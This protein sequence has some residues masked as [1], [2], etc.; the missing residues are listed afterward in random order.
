MKLLHNALIHTLDP[1]IPAA[2]TIAIENGRVLA[3]GGTELLELGKTGDREDLGGR[4]VLPG[5]IDAHIHL[6]EYTLSL[7]I[8][9]CEVET[10]AEILKRVAERVDRTPAGEWV[11]GHGWNQNTWG[12]EWPKAA[13]LDEI[14]PQNPVY[15]TAKS[16][17]VSWANSLALKLAGISESTP[18]PK[19]GRIQHDSHGS[20]TGLLFEDAVKLLEKAI[21]EPDPFSLGE[22][23]KQIIA[24]L[25]QM[26]LT[27]VHDFDKRT[28]FQALQI[29]HERGDLRFRVVKSIPLDVLPQAASLGL[30]TGFG[31]D[32]LRVGAVKLFADG[33]LGP[34]TG[35]MFE[36]YVD[37]PE[38]CGI[39]VLDHEQLFEY[40]RLAVDNGISLAVHAI[41]D[42]AVHE[43]LEGFE[44]LREYER[45]HGLPQF[46]HRIEHVQA[47]RP[48]DI[49]RLA[50]LGLIASMQP[51]HAPSDM[52]VAESALGNRVAYCYAWRSQIEAGARLAFGSDAPVEPPNP[53]YGLH[54]AV[55]RRR[56]DGSPGKDGWIPEQR[57]SIAK[58]LEAFTQGAAYAAG[59]DQ[60]LGRLSPG[61][62]ADLIVM[63]TDPLSCDPEAIYGIKPTA[64][65]VGGEWVWLK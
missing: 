31:D 38:N 8:V 9:D 10:K 34:H 55:T 32:L 4:T 14:S 63:D 50:K 45:T 21:P 56:R 24:G 2:S 39:L 16:L 36:P 53:F 44:R 51:I 25:W 65:M 43:V 11:R 22:E 37:E 57:I 60:Y 7:Q 64:T 13:D 46:R 40:G 33:A 27:G 1:E 17:H 42:R 58:A 28:C 47:I 5:L 62:L 54:A 3:V 23:F 29:L 26:G 15:L 49:D 61:F 30:R 48:D 6:Q 12:G 20:P 59:M 52:L 18:D 19:D 35:A 41:G